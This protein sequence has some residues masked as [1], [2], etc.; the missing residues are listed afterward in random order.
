MSSEDRTHSAPLTPASGCG[1]G[2]H[3]D[4]AEH[5]AATQSSM[6][7]EE[8]RIRRVVE[9]AITRALFP[10][11]ATR[12]LFLK[13]AGSTAAA[14]IAQFFP[15]SIASEAFAQAATPEKKDLKVGFIPITCATPIIM[16]QPMG[17]YAKHGL[18]VEVVKTAGLGGDPR[19]DA[20]QGIRRRAHALADA[21][22]DHAGRRLEAD[23]LHHAGGREHQRPGD[24]ARDQA[25]GQAR[26]EA[27]EGLQVRRA[28]RLL[29]AQLPAALLPRR[30][31]PRPRQG[32]PDPRGAAAGDGGQPARGQH[33]RLSWRPT[34]STSAR[35]TTEWASSTCCRRRSGTATRA[36]PS[37]PQGVRHADTRTPIAALLKAIVDATAYA[38]K[39]ENRK[40]IA[41]AIAPANYLNQPVTVVEQVLTGT[42]RRRAGQRAARCPTASTSIRSPTIRSR[43]GSSRR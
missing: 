39:P 11:S 32:H 10:H 28:V 22:R 33:R 18:N 5:L 36:A 17:F 40:Q 26:P 34:R 16:A 13:A 1:C 3:H 38:T 9:A 29:D 15:I 12:R 31:R 2:H 14:A 41:E 6:P 37:P 35:S 25:Q 30:A 19:Q 27:V 20:Q 7:E 43:S 4:E 23:P 42:V 24:H 8:A 21:A